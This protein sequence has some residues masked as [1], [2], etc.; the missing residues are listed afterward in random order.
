MGEDDDYVPD[1]ET[2]EFPSEHE[3]PPA[4][5]VEGTLEAAEAAVSGQRYPTDASSLKAEYATA[6]DEVTNETESLADVFDRLVPE[7]YETPEEAREAVLGELTGRAGFEHGDLA[8]YNPERELDA[9]DLVED[10]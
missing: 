10:E 4:E 2:E 5:H 9:M 1:E 8:E 7:Q 6:R 3:E